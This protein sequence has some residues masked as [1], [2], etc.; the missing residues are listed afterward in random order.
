[1]REYHIRKGPHL[2]GSGACPDDYDVPHGPDEVV[3]DGPPNGPL[4]TQ[5]LGEEAYWNLDTLQWDVVQPP[6]EVLWGRVRLKRDKL[7]TACDWV[8]TR[9]QEAG[10]PVP[11]PWRV[12]RQALRDITTQPDPMN[13]VWPVAP[14][15]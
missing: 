3:C 12:Y 2:M 8:V 6:V 10:E 7:L 5:P 13:I 9:A 14:A 15:A 4:T 11:E 1:M